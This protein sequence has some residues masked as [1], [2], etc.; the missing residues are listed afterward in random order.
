MKW[1]RAGT[2]LFIQAV[3]PPL[4]LNESLQRREN[5]TKHCIWCFLHMQFSLNQ[6]AYPHYSFYNLINVLFWKIAKFEQFLS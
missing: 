4:S 5:L 3:S 1:H 2:A 6:L